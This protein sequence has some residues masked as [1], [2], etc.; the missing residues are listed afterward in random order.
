MPDIHKVMENHRL[1]YGTGITKNIDFRMSKLRLL[2]DAIVK[3]EDEIMEA[4]K[5]DLNKASFEAYETEVGFILQELSFTIKSLRKWAR[6]RKVQTP[7][8]H[9]PATSTI[10]SEPYGVALIM[11]PWNYPFQLTIGPLIGAIAA[12]NCA[13]VKPSEY[14]Y[15]TA[16]VLEKLLKEIFEEKYVSVVRGGRDANSSLLNEKFDYI[17][18]TG[19]VP[20]G[21][22][23]ME[24]AAKHLTP[25]TLELGGKS[26]CVV[27]ETANVDLAAKRIAW[28]KFL[29]AGQTCVAPDYLF[30]HKKVSKQLIAGI[31][32][33]VKAF[34]GINPE[35]NDEYPRIITQ[36]HYERLLHLLE[37]EEIAIGGQHNDAT[38]QLAPTVITN[39]T[40]SSPVMQEEIFGPILPV[41][42]FESFDDA[43][44]MINARPKPLAF[45]LF[46]E[47][48]ERENKAM[49][50][51][52]F[53]G[54]CVN[55]TVIHLSSPYLRFGGVGDSGMG[56]YHG[57][58][59]F[60]TFTHYKSV[61][62]KANHMDIPVRYPP[63]K[64]RLNLLKRIMK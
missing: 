26:P 2:Y 53:G 17:F 5:K 57:K 62:K 55:D 11:S 12:G 1:Y 47:N 38:R 48:Q 44:A 35:T 8:M 25:V 42:A 14:S 32:K 4:L 28:G 15:Y 18:F 39:V 34:Y 43:I 21:K 59:S 22:V 58:G 61:M 24:A 54:G 13:V 16:E 9:F 40:W 56:Q 37:N 27:D 7:L 29:N 36:K 33:Y 19:S 10:Y 3:Y 52:S 45:Y 31:E 60:D 23:V 50:N 41:L 46:T 20:V 51:V 49:Q 30:V 63:F 6:P 64:D